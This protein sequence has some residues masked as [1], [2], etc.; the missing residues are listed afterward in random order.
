MKNISQMAPLKSRCVK[1]KKT[2][3]SDVECVGRDNEM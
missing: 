3:Q 2:S 1:Y